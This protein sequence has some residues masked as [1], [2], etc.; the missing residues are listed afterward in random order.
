MT[1]KNRGDRR[2]DELARVEFT[3]SPKEVFEAFA[4][5][6]H[7][8]R[9]ITTRWDTELGMAAADVRAALKAARTPASR[10]GTSGGAVD[11]QRRKARRVAR[12]VARAQTLVAELG[13][14]A[15]R[16]HREYTR[17]FLT[18]PAHAA[19]N[20]TTNTTTAI[21]AAGDA[22]HDGHGGKRVRDEGA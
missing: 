17:Q 15:D 9:R 11:H 12:R 14:H 7:A 3:G 1:R 21:E 18:T 19:R 6:A 22:K 5:Y 16:L 8:L 4:R 13:R 20:T 10:A 2:L